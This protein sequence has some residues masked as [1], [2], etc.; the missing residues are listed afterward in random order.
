MTSVARVASM[1]QEHFQRHTDG[2]TRAKRIMVDGKG[3]VYKMILFD[4]KRR[5][6]S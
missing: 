3:K 4:E 6:R 2:I 1:R 5:R